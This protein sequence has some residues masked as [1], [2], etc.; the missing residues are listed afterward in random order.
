MAKQYRFRCENKYGD[1]AKGEPSC[2]IGSQSPPNNQVLF[3]LAELKGQ[4]FPPACPHPECKKPLKPIGEMPSEMAGPAGGPARK[5]GITSSSAVKAV[6]I[7]SSAVVLIGVLT[8]Y[9]YRRSLKPQI[10]G[11]TREVDFGTLDV[12]ASATREILIRNEGRGPL[13]ISHWDAAPSLFSVDQDALLIAPGGNGSVRIAF[14]GSTG[15]QAAGRLVIHSNDPEYPEV[16]IALRAEVT[17]DPWKILDDYYD[18]ST[19]TTTK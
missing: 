14:S 9:L 11:L 8:V 7:V 17:D 13:R 6:L 3:T 2:K 19:I 10:A 5:S 1:P 18:R 15:G 12:G 16:E 4:P